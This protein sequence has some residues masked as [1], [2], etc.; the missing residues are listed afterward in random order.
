MLNNKNSTVSLISILGMGGVF[1]ILQGKAKQHVMRDFSKTPID[2]DEKL[3]NWLKYYN[4]TAPLSTVG[5]F[6]SKDPVSS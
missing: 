2:T 4:M 1:V 6:V 3:E 5:T